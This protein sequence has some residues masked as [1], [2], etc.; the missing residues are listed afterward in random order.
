M[1]S[2]SLTRR[3][4]LGA[5]LAAGL[6]LAK[7]SDTNRGAGLW[8]PS[9]GAP[10]LITSPRRRP[11]IPNGVQSG[12]VTPSRAIIWSR[13]DRPARMEVEWSTSDQ[14][15][16]ARRISGPAALES[17]AYT[18]KVD[19]RDLPPAEQI[20]YRVRFESLELPGT[21]SEP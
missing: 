18:A 9:D 20:V 15:T 11:L 13:S 2:D 5:S 17:T 21:W 3:G 6:S 8:L 4:F 12:D 10:G 14:F 19:L 7:G 1:S 16:N